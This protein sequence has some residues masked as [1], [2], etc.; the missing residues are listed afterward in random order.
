[1]KHKLSLYFAFVMLIGAFALPVLGSAQ[2]APA[3]E[4]AEFR[5]QNIESPGVT[6]QPYQVK[7]RLRIGTVVQIDP[8]ASDTV[9]PATQD[10]LDGAFG[11]IVT[12]ANLPIQ[13]TTGENQMYVSTAGRHSALVSNENGPIKSGDFLVI[14]SLS[15]TLMKS[16]PKQKLVFAKAL[17]NFDGKNN[18]LGV[19]TLQDDSGRPLQQVGIGLIPVA[20]EIIKNPEEVSTKADLPDFLQRVG[21]AIAEKEV[22]PVRIYIGTAIVVLSILIALAVLYVGVRTAIIS[23]GR[24][25]LSKKSI[26]WGLLQVI[27]TSVLVLIIGLFTVYLLL[28]L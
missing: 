5:T 24:N 14:S 3:E 19:K 25:P 28:R 1:M 22:S 9:I 11:V 13:V 27:L 7:K 4:E 17:T 2:E 20:I 8:A 16:S 6:P 23:I 10:K 12:G 15:G 18:I 26:F 21:K